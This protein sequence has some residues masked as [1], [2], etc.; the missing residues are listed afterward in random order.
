MLYVDTSALLKRYVHEHDSAVA[1]AH[2]AGDRVLITSTLTEVEVRRNLTRL[3]D[4]EAL[5]AARAAFAIDLD[6]FALVLLDVTVMSNAAQIA[7]STLCR[8][9]DAVHLAAARRAGPNI[10]VLTFDAR[11]A[12][13]ARQL[14]LTTIG[15]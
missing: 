7:E 8:S 3:L 2:M 9:L 12:H 10:T 15:A 6:S 13:V 5:L 14:D 4:G 1:A 11:Q